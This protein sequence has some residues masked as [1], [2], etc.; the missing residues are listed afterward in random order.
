MAIMDDSQS[1][2]HLSARPGQEF[3]VELKTYPG[4]G[5]MWRYASSD[6]P[7]L[8]SD[9]TQTLDDSIGAAAIQVFTLRADNPGSYD[10]IFE[11]KRAWEPSPRDRKEIKVDVV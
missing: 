1:P 8:I 7:Q 6:G 2:T 9:T 3:K 4:S 5:A 10:L 11:L